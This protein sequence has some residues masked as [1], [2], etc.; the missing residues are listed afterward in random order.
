[1]F[2]FQY[3]K[4]NKGAIA[5]SFDTYIL[6]YILANNLFLNATNVPYVTPFFVRFCCYFIVEDIF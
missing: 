5:I 3:L 1:M 4:T 6:A 2:L